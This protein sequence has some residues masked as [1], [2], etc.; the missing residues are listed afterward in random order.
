MFSVEDPAG[1]ARFGFKFGKGGVHAAR[2]MMLAEVQ[3]LF[4]VVPDAAQRAD[5]RQAIVDDNLLD[6]PTV[7]ARKLSFRHLCELYALDP[8]SC[9]FRIFRRLWSHQRDAQPVLAL[10]LSLARDALLRISAPIIRDA[11]PGAQVTREQMEQRF[12]EWSQGGFSPTS[13]E[14]IAQRVNG[15]WTQ[16]G[17]LSGHVKKIRARPLITPVNISFGLFLAYLEGRLAQ[18]LFSS[19]WVLVLDLPEEQLIELTQA[20]AQRGLLVFRRTGGVMEVRF[21]DYLSEQ[22]QGWLNEQA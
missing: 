6:K 13:I 5:Y 2:T 20:A 21:P 19:D 15:S 18:R 17:Y 4:E 3:R 22:E 1:L 7:N 14:A 12:T 10:Q 16:A 9:L 8:G 11:P